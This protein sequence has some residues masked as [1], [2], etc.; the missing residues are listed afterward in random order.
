MLTDGKPKQRVH[1]L[2][3]HTSL[4]DLGTNQQSSIK[5]QNQRDFRPTFVAKLRYFGP[6]LTLLSY[7]CSQTRPA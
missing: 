1:S 7:D 2:G 6:S 5:K 4:K 3:D